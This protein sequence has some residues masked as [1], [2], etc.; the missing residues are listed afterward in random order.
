MNTS[1]SFRAAVVQMV[2]TASVHDNLQR[3]AAL[4]GRAVADGAQLAVL[5]ENFAL[6]SSSKLRA[7]SQAEISSDGPIRSF[8][9]ASARKYG[10]WLVGGSLP[11]PTGTPKVYAASFLLDAQGNERAC[12][13]KMHLF[14]VDVADA[15]G[16]YRESDT[17]APG[18]EVV[19]VTTPFGKLGLSICYDLRFPE[20]YRAL[21]QQQV[22]IITVPSAFTE[23]T[24]QAHW[25]T[26]LQARAIENCCYVLAPNQGGRHS[27][28]RVTWGHSMIV[29]PWGRVLAA[30]EKGEGVAIAD[31]NMDHLHDL[32]RRM[33]LRAHQRIHVPERPGR[34]PA[35]C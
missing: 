9:A 28:K 35:G 12:Y 27:A 3:A 34:S 22:D 29:D 24:G 10:I 31:L 23:H 17:L 20:L 6:L 4:I 7:C 8:L 11:L 15:Q 1:G 21:F 26:L 18:D 30:C 32:R 25:Q 19:S 14:D 16:S 13:R 2:S 33:P 5:P